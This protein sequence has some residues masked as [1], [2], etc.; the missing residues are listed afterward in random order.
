MKHP[1]CAERGTHWEEPDKK[2]HCVDDKEG[3]IY[4]RKK[5]SFI[6]GRGFQLLAGVSDISDNYHQKPLNRWEEPDKKKHCK[7]D[8][9]FRRKKFSVVKKEVFSSK[10]RGI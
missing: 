5:I 8:A 1:S 10:R 2:K 9:N 3:F 7:Y 6:G 4:K